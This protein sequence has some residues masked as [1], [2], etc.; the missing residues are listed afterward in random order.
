[1]SSVTAVGGSDNTQFDIT[2]P[3]QN[4]AGAYT[5]VISPSIFDFGGNSLGQSFTVHFILRSGSSSRAPAISQAPPMDLRP[6]DAG[7]SMIVAGTSPGYA[8]STL[9]SGTRLQLGRG[10]GDKPSSAVA[11]S[12]QRVAHERIPGEA[13]A[14]S[15][16]FGRLS[17]STRLSGEDLFGSVK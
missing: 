6:G 8:T 14:R 13:S 10:E 3:S 2:F 17:N 15:D 7:S 4:V 1:V 11:I 12:A 5:M 9:T 16:I